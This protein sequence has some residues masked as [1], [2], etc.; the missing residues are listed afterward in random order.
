MTGPVEEV[1]VECPKCG[2]SYSTFYQGSM[3][4]ELDDFDQEYLR[5]MSTGT[6]PDCGGVVE[7]GSLVVESDGTWRWPDGS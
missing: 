2:H 7:L 1:T 5:D 3:N 6:C 4:L